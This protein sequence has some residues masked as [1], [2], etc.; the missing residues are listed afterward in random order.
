[1]QNMVVHKIKYIILLADYF[2]FKEKSK[3]TEIWKVR[4]YNRETAKK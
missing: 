3:M 4:N 2:L 1:M